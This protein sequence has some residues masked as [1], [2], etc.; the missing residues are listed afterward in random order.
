MECID[1]LPQ[2]KNTMNFLNWFSKYNLIPKG[3]ALK[4]LLLS[5]EAIEDV[6][7]EEFKKFELKSKRK[8]FYRM[9]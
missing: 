7:L 2:N 8:K 9:Q 4:L 5:N 6:K 1:E 3:I